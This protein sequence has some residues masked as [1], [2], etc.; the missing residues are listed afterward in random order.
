DEEVAVPDELAGHVPGLGE[1]GPV[2][3]VVEARLEDLQ[4]RLAG[5]ARTAVRLLVVPAELLLQ[6]P[7]DSARLLLLPQLQQ[8]LGLLGAPAAVLARRERPGLERALRAVALA[9]LQEELH[10]LPPA[11]AAVGT[12]VSRHRLASPLS[13]PTPLRRT[14]AVVRLRIDICDRT[15]RQ[16]GRPQRALP[17][18][19][20][21][22]GTLH[23][24]VDVAHAAP[25]G[26]TR[27]R[28]GGVRSREG[29]LVARPLESGLPRGRRRDDGT[30]RV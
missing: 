1:T 26:T 25:Q 20:A 19:P 29:R 9:A 30:G 12:C 23:S 15:P 27:C 14:A 18:L 13:D 28:L 22:P 8:V 16:A 11:A 4:Q 5:L 24:H 2:H 17:A 7:V 3:D 10:L 6:H 21:R